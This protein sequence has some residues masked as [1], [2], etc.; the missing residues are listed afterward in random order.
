MDSFDI[1]S[2]VFSYKEANLSL[3]FS[4]ADTSR[5][6]TIPLG[7]PNIPEIFKGQ[8]TTKSVMANKKEVKAYLKKSGVSVCGFGAA[9][10]G[11]QNAKRNSFKPKRV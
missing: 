11:L 10:I 5:C 9:N 1:G 6:T 7:V 2:N 4:G 8:K 3:I